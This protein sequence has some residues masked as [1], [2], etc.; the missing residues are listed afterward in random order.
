MEL[1]LEVAAIVTIIAMDTDMGMD[2]D[3]VTG[4]E[5]TTKNLKKRNLNLTDSSLKNPK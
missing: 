4:M 2:M 3:M 5:D 1:K